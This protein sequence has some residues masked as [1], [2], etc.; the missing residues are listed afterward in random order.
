[1]RTK[2]TKK[3]F[4]FVE[5][6]DM[7]ID[8]WKKKAEGSIKTGIEEEV[9]ALD[10]LRTAKNPDA[11]SQAEWDLRK[12]RNKVR[13][14]ERI[15]NNKIPKLA[16]QRAEIQTQPMAFLPDESIQR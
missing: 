1:M 16:K 4:L 14:G 5:Q 10:A 7:A 11:E 9:T 8:G 15:L 3:R 6:V 2:R 13:Y 12:A